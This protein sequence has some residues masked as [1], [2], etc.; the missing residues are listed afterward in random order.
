MKAVKKRAANTPVASWCETV[1][2]A[3][4]G[5]ALV[6]ALALADADRDPEAADAEVAIDVAEVAD[7]AEE[8]LEL[9][10]IAVAL[11]LPHF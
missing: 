1:T 10:S 5:V 8:G 2:A 6:L 9:P 3:L 11:R 4:L 7:E